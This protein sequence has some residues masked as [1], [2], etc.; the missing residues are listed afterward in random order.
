MK[1][2]KLQTNFSM[3]ENTNVCS[4]SIDW[5]II[6]SQMICFSLRI[7][8]TRSVYIYIY[9]RDLHIA[10]TTRQ[11]MFVNWRIYVSEKL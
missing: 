1:Y 8:L 5:Q 6:I 10:Q 3:F 4:D 2:R 7:Y 11:N 9:F